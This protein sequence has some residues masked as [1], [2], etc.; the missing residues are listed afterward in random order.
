[1]GKQIDSVIVDCARDDM[2]IGRRDLQFYDIFV[3][4][5]TFYWQSITQMLIYHNENKSFKEIGTSAKYIFIYT[6]NVYN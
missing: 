2:P 1:M 5:I 4:I 6:I 3:K